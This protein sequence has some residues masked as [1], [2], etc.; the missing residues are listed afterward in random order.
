VLTKQ[1]L[2]ANLEVPPT[3][4]SLLRYVRDSKNLT[5]QCPLLVNTD[6]VVGRSNVRFTP[7]ESG[8]WESAVKD[9]LCAKADIKLR[10]TFG[11]A[12]PAASRYYRNRRTSSSLSGLAVDRAKVKEPRPEVH[13]AGALV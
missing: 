12:A 11:A 10:L 9:P 13:S 4:T 1:F 6:I 5:A 8:H 3:I 2:R 7:R